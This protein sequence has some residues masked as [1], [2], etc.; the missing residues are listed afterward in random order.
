VAPADGVATVVYHSIVMPYLGREGL[1]RFA[2]IVR[3]AGARATREA[4]LAWLCLEASPREDGGFDHCVFLTLWPGGERRV[5]AQST[6]HGPP[7]R[8]LAP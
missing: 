6:P 7:V 8:W 5:L 1:R 2:E 4:P 3:A